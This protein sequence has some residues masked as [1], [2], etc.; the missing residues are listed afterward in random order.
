MYGMCR[1]ASDDCLAQETQSICG[2]FPESIDCP[3]N[4]EKGEA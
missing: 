2:L 4:I 3:Y 1:V